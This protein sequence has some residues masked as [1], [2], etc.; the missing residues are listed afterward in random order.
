MA[1]QAAKGAE[2]DI[3]GLDLSRN[4]MSVACGK[5]DPDARASYQLV[6]G[7]ALAMPF[8]DASFDKA[9]VAYGVRNMPD[10]RRFAQEAFRV[11]R[12]GGRFAVVELSLPRNRA[13]RAMYLLYLTKLL[14]VVGGI[15]SGNRAAYDYLAES[16]VDFPPPSQVEL[17][18]EQAGFEI[19]VSKAQMM[20]ICHVYIM[21]RPE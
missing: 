6:Q 16:I 17:T 12:P 9:M 13:V 5:W 11:L 19:T 15:R 18:M 1:V 20:N 21:R 3:T 14:P 8:R 2:C 7:D 10:M 4:M